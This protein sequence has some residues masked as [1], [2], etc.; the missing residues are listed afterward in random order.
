[1]KDKRVYASDNDCLLTVI[2][3]HGDSFTKTFTHQFSHLSRCQS[4]FVDHVRVKS[5]Y[6]E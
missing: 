3:T 5:T 6:Q 2:T 4:N 1:M